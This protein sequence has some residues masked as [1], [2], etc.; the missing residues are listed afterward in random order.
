MFMQHLRYR[1]KSVKPLWAAPIIVPKSSEDV[2]WFAGLF[3]GE[4]WVACLPAGGI[5]V[6]IGMT[7]KD[8]L[9]RVQTLFGGSLNGPYPRKNER[10]KPMFVWKV[11]GIRNAELIFELISPFLGERRLAQFTE[12]IAKWRA[13]PAK[14]R[15]NWESV[16]ETI[17]VAK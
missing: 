11:S 9:R 16:G 12:A 6:V 17:S 14:R 4:G 5:V 3:E 10:A 8:V 15:R 7:D 13:H 2:A 1:A